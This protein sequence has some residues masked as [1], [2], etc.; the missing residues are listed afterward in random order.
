MIKL[1][2]ELVRSE[3]KEIM[4]LLKRNNALLEEISLKIGRDVRCGDVDELEFEGD[5]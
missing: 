1:T 4:K 3:L 2:D 5:K